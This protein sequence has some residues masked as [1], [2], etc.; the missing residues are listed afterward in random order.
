MDV[1]RQ[2]VVFWHVSLVERERRP[3]S[4][5]EVGR[6]GRGRPLVGLSLSHSE[7]ADVA[8]MASAPNTKAKSARS[9]H[10]EEGITH[11]AWRDHVGLES[12]AFR[13]SLGRSRQQDVQACF[14]RFSA[15]NRASIIVHPTERTHC[16]QVSAPFPKLCGCPVEPIDSPVATFAG[17]PCS[18]CQGRPNVYDSVILL[19]PW[20]W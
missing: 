4:R 10:R 3:F 12:C 8:T 5:C 17:F 13:A 11:Q 7:A 16:M 1:F 2:R 9:A 15:S 18:L 6:E 19:H 20:R 14:P